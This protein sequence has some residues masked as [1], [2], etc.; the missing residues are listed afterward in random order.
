L[1][2]FV[3]DNGSNKTKNSGRAKNENEDKKGRPAVD[4]VKKIMCKGVKYF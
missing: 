2:I 4:F 1:T 3:V